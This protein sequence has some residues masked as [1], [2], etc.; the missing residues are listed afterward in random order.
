MVTIFKKIITGICLSASIVLS[1]HATLTEDK[2]AVYNQASAGNEDQIEPAYK[3]FS[4]LIKEDG[5]SYLTL[6]YFGS[7]NT[8]QGRA[9]WMPW[10]KIKHVEQG[11]ANINKGLT[12]LE[13]D[14]VKLGQQNRF[15]ALRESHIARAIAA[16]TLSDLPDR[17]NQF[18]RGYDLFLILLAEPNFQSEPF[19][20][21]SWIYTYAIKAALRADDRPQAAKWLNVMLAEDKTSPQTVIA[22]AIIAD[23]K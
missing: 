17:F 23:A 12:L 19:V 4:Q 18:E 10:T 1:A 15:N 7:I 22:Q 8:L 14:T 20:S 5:T 16:A 2:I 9:A 11:V 21:R 3:I 6:I 13:N